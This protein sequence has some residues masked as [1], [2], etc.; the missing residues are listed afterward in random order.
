M[1]IKITM[2][3]GIKATILN[4]KSIDQVINYIEKCKKKNELYKISDEDG[5][6]MALNPDHIIA[7]EICKD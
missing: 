3:I 1:K 7:I 6:Y 2:T 4:F 5:I